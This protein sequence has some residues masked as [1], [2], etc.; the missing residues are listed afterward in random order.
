MLPEEFDGNDP[1]AT[2]TLAICQSTKHLSMK[3]TQ[4]NELFCFL[5]AIDVDVCQ[6]RDV[7]TVGSVTI[8]IVRWWSGFQGQRF[9]G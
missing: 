6:S 7:F 5:C 9:A 3:L 1:M 2:A 8:K 4:L